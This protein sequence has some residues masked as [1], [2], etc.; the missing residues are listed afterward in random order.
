MILFLTFLAIIMIFAAGFLSGLLNLAAI[1][2][3][4]K[5]PPFLRDRKRHLT[6]RV[7]EYT[8]LVIALYLLVVTSGII[9]AFIYYLFME[10]GLP[11]LL[12]P[13]YKKYFGIPSEVLE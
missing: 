10:Y 7:V 3:E 12:K 1:E 2:P 5:K 9:M 4:E 11:R 8:L 13:V 6:G